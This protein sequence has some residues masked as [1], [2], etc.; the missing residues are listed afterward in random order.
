MIWG[1]IAGGAGLGER[2]LPLAAPGASGDS[3]SWFRCSIEIETCVSPL[4][5]W[6]EKEGRRGVFGGVSVKEG[7]GSSESVTVERVLAR[8]TKVGKTRRVRATTRRTE[9]RTPTGVCSDTGVI[10]VSR[11]ETILAF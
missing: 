11:Q 5:G 1:S 6:R 7:A 10:G 9:Q 2:M 3:I 8:Q 4:P